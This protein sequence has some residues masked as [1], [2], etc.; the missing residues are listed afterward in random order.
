MYCCVNPETAGI[1]CLERTMVGSNCQTPQKTILVLTV[2][3]SVGLVYD[4]DNF[5]SGVIG[6]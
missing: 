3:P 6:C 5:D 4:E 2:I 1:L